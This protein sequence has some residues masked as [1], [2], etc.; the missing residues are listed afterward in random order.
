MSDKINLF[1]KLKYQNPNRRLI[2]SE[3]LYKSADAMIGY[4]NNSMLW[5]NGEIYINLGV[6]TRRRKK[7]RKDNDNE[8]R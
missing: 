3:S 1:R 4:H 6:W 7:S 5:N 2:D 8:K